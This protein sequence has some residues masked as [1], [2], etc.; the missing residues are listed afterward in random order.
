MDPLESGVDARDRGTIV[1]EVLAGFV[2][3]RHAEGLAG[4]RLAQLIRAGQGRLRAL[5]HIERVTAF[6]WPV[7]EKVAVWFCGWG[8]QAAR[9]PAPYAVEQGGALLIPLADGSSFRLRGRADRIDVLHDGS[10]AIVD[11]KTGQP[12]SGQ[13]VGTGLEPQL[14]LTAYMAAAACS[15]ARRRGRSSSSPM[16][17][18]APLRLRWNWSS[19]VPTRRRSGREAAE[20]HIA[21]CAALSSGCAPAR[22]ASCRAGCRRR[23][24]TADP[25]II[26]RACANGWWVSWSSPH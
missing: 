19:S 8:G 13:H 24:A 15:T 5:R 18:W 25:T 17:R 23:S 12:P 1:H 6:W 10:L 9:E 16:S 26:W 22:T 21:A 3:E 2:K 4:R 20:E 14:T 11:Y 7:F